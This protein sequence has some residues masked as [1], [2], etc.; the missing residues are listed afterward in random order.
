MSTYLDKLHNSE[1]QHA[2][3]MHPYKVHAIKTFVPHYCNLPIYLST[4]L[5]IPIILL[6]RVYL[7]VFERVWEN[8]VNFSLG[9][10]QSIE[11]VVWKEGE[12]N[13]ASSNILLFP[14]HGYWSRPMEFGGKAL[15]NVCKNSRG[16]KGRIKII[17]QIFSRFKSALLHWDKWARVLPSLIG[18][19]PRK[20]IALMLI[21]ARWEPGPIGDTLALDMGVHRN[22]QEV[23]LDW[24]KVS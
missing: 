22:S 4:E 6:L 10:K 1:L 8:A 14:T 9:L 7:W 2:W 15:Q 20:L 5:P 23:F 21:Y 3:I 11:N 19:A 18:V 17:S 16:G 24:G 12:A 13:M